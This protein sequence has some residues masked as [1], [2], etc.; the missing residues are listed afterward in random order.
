MMEQA[1]LRTELLIEPESLWEQRNE[2]NFRI[3][4]LGSEGAYGRA[5]I[6]GAVRLPV[7]PWLKETEGGVHVMNADTF[8]SLMSGVGVSNETRVVA[9]DAF[10]TSFATRLWWVLN[11]YGHTNVQVLNGGWHRWIAEGRQVT[12][13]GITPPAGSF[14]PAPEEAIICRLDDVK[15]AVENP[16]IQILNVLTEGWY[17][18]TV[19]PFD[20]KRVG[21]IPGSVNIPIERFLTDDDRQTFRSAPELQAIV[22]DAG[23]SPEKETIVHC[24]AG[25]RTTMGVF[26]LALLGW[27]RVRAY[28]ASMAEWANRDDTAMVVG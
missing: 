7:H 28:D 14:A 10:N 18:G 25:I 8:S 15:A 11:F 19:N 6:P 21:R 22:R 12:T 9:Y 4:D 26:V 17:R 13:K 2:T 24:Q 1:Y 5:H 20:N 16:D 27:D 3:I 23:L